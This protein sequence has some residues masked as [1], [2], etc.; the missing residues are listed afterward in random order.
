M[1]NVEYEKKMIKKKWNTEFSISILTR[2]V[3]HVFFPF[4]F[5][6]HVWIINRL[7]CIPKCTYLIVIQL[8]YLL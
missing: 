7:I 5:H 8:R 2:Y 3:R 6:L 1:L 4:E